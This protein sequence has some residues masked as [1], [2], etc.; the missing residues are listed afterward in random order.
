MARWPL[1]YHQRT[2]AWDSPHTAGKDP[3]TRFNIEFSHTALGAMVRNKC[4]LG[5]SGAP[6][7]YISQTIK[8]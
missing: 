7:V 5:T 6:I 1:W 3:N 8:L 2:S 4:G